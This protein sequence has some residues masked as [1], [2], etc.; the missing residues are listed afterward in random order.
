MPAPHDGA[1]LHQGADDAQDRERKIEK[2]VARPVLERQQNK[3]T[4]EQKGDVFDAGG[5]EDFPETDAL[6]NRE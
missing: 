3:V 1:P 2:R 5:A 6:G 4:E